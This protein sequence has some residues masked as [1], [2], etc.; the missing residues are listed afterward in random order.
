MCSCA[1]VLLS[2]LILASS[3]RA[4]N[5]FAVV[6]VVQRGALAAAC[7]CPA[8]LTW[9]VCIRIAWCTVHYGTASLAWGRGC[10]STRMF[11][12][13]RY[14]EAISF[15]SASPCGAPASCLRLDCWSTAMLSV[16]LFPACCSRP[17]D[18]QPVH[19]HNWTL[20]SVE[21]WFQDL[22]SGQPEH[23]NIPILLGRTAFPL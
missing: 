7:G 6:R 14:S 12:M 23:H 18:V 20:Y 5:H 4:S 13:F 21:A 2:A 22:T 1:S 9:I 19:Q 11:Q 15:L 16:Q 17:R 10:W 3:F 8:G